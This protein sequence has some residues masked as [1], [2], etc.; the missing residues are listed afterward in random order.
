MKKVQ[1]IGKRFIEKIGV[2]GK[3]PGKFWN[4]RGRKRKRRELEDCD[5]RFEG[6][7]GR[8]GVGTEDCGTRFTKK[9]NIRRVR[10]Q[11]LFIW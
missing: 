1:E 6:R 4:K 3:W 11:Q 2:R 9:D 5:E 8:N 10:S 7:E